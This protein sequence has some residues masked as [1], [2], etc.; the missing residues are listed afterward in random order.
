MGLYRDLYKEQSTVEISLIQILTIAVI[1]MVTFVLPA[2]LIV[3]EQQRQ[4]QNNIPYTATALQQRQA[5]DQLNGRV[6]GATTDTSNKVRVPFTTYY[7]DL[8]DESTMLTLGGSV[9]LGIGILGIAYL[10]YTRP[11][12]QPQLALQEDTIT[13]WN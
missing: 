13:P 9:M 5:Q 4:A 6:A 10:I 3:S 8:T 12:S 2:Q 11:K 7:I 1:V